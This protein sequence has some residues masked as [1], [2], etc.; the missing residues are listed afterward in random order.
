MP[1]ASDRFAALHTL[2]GEA[3]LPFGLSVFGWFEPLSDEI[4]GG[5]GNTNNWLMAALIGNRP[6]DGQHRMWPVFCA[7]PENSDGLPDP[8]DRWTKRV[9]DPIADEFSAEVAYPFGVETYPFQRW[10]KRVMGLQASPLGILI[11]P[12]HG[13]WTGFRAALIFP[14][15]FDFPSQVHR[16]HPCD[17]CSEKPCLTACPIGAFS[18]SGFAVND[19]RDHVVSRQSPDCLDI[20][21][22]ARAACPVGI[23]YTAAQIRFHMAAFAPDANTPRR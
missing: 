22:I 19:C 16:Q 13:L 8:L 1:S 17:T 2:L 14:E 15:T 21:C 18:D 4:Q 9:I 5:L 6:V 12:D 20:G 11:D 3:L 10:A 7:S 23:P